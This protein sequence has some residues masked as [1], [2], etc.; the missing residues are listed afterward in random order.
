M[1]KRQK[2]K[3]YKKIY[4]IGKKCASGTKR[5]DIPTVLVESI[6]LG[7]PKEYLSKRENEFAQQYKEFLN[8]NKLIWESDP[9]NGGVKY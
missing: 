5:L 3:R 2:K 9:T 1:N 7:I 8:V 4:Y 6:F